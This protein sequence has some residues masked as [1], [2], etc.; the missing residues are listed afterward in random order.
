M[1]KMS[2]AAAI[3]ELA[4]A[5]SCMMREAL[6]LSLTQLAGNMYLLRAISTVVSSQNSTQCQQ[7]VK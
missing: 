7:K 1:N 6:G 4:F 5:C 2:S 3:M